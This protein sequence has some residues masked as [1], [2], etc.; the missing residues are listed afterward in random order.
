MLKSEG[1]ACCQV[2]NCKTCQE[3]TG[4]QLVWRKIRASFCFD[5]QRASGETRGREGNSDSGGLKAVEKERT[6][7]R[8]QLQPGADAGHYI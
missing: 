6:A 5:R 1:Q 2:T 3:G 8:Q 4:K 7:A